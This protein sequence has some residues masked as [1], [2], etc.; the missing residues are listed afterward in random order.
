MILGMNHFTAIAADPVATLAFYENLLGLK[1]GYRPDLV[2][3]LS[4]NLKT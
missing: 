2:S 3:A 4:R 1:T